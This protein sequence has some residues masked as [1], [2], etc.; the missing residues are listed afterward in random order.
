M[1]TIYGERGIG[2]FIVIAIVE[3]FIFTLVLAGVIYTAPAS[4]PDNRPVIVE[5]IVNEP[6]KKKLETEIP[7]TILPFQRTDIPNEL[8]PLRFTQNVQRYL[9][10]A[11]S[12]GG[13][14]NL[15][16]RTRASNQNPDRLSLGGASSP[17][18]SRDSLDDDANAT[19][20][21][22]PL[23][24]KP[25]RYGLSERRGGPDADTQQSTRGTGGSNLAGNLATG[26]MRDT[27]TERVTGGEGY[28]ISI[29]GEVSGRGFSLG[30]PLQTEGKQGGGVQLSFKVQPDGTVFDVRIKPGPKTTVGEARLKQKAIEYVENIRFS[31][32]PQSVSQVVQSGEIFIKFTTQPNR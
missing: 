25:G 12:K 13:L 18:R 17:G 24:E 30:N 22:K 29:S 32:L 27:G 8:P 23:V 28:E 3:H 15:P 19:V 11:P 16:S 9:G 26:G 5:I 20:R 7:V 6:E 4:K 31:S 21:A 14:P 1:T 2:I 10:D